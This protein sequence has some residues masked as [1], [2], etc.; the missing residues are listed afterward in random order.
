MDRPRQIMQLIDQTF[1]EYD[2]CKLA[3]F[4]GLKCLCERDVKLI[5]E[6]IE[7]KGDENYEV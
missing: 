3:K 7:F 1:K 2:Y 5:K 6:F 4:R